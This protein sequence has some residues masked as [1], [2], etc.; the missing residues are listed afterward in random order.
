[1]GTLRQTF[2]Y[3]SLLTVLRVLSVIYAQMDRAVIGIALAAAAVARY[4]IAFRI[5]SVA[6]LALTVASSS[7]FPAAAYNAA[8]GDVDKQRALYLRG[9]KYAV[10]LAVPVTLAAMIYARY[11]ILAWVGHRYVGMTT[12]AQLFLAFP[13][14]WCVHQVGIPMLIGLGRVKPVVGLQ[15]ACTVVNLIASI[16][17]VSYF[18][19][20]GAIAGTII[21]FGIVW[22]PYLR[23]TISTFEVTGGWWFRQIVAPNL[24]GAFVQVAF[25]ALTIAIAAQ[26]HTLWAVLL[27][28]LASAAANLAVFALVGL[29]RAER[30]NLRRHLRVG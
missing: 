25:G 5:E 11:L 1:M 15:L 28:C 10:A 6:T 9:S 23:L 8:R 27:L 7:V 19:I 21:G 14:F 13:L 30:S 18:G 4:E 17:L 2:A 16:V 22:W 29:D 3:G 26:H 24:P 20:L 12:A